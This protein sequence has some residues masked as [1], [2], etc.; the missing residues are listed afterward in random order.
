MPTKVINLDELSQEIGRYSKG[1]ID[2]VR[3]AVASGIMKSI[4]NL[5]AA[6]PVDTGLYANSW[7]YRKEQNNV[8]IGNYAPHAGII[9]MGARP[10]KAPLYP[11]LAWAK[12]VLRDP[13]QPPDYSPE[14][15][16]LAIGTRNKIE[17]YGL[18]PRH[19]MQQNIPMILEN[20]EM[21]LKRARS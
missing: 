2:V 21:E 18:A 20:I 5:V 1:H 13:S 9:E 17:R 19:I 16:R 14:V 12:R 10:F 3:N 7:D 4:P 11:L 15:W 6:S 8:T